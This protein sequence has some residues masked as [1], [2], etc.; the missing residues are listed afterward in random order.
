[1]E[2]FLNKDIAMQIEKEKEIGMLTTYEVVLNTDK[3]LVLREASFINI[4]EKNPGQKVNS[5]LLSKSELDI[6]FDAMRG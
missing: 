3:M 2:K 1:M 4:Y 5:V 6:I